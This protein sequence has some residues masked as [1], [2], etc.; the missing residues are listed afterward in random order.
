[1]KPRLDDKNVELAKILDELLAADVKIT[2]REVSRRHSSLRNASDFSRNGER[3]TLIE[4]AK[5]RQSQLRTT[6]NPHAERATS[7][8]NKLEQ[9]S[10]QVV[11]LEAQV[12]ALVASHAGCIQAVLHAGGMSAVERFWKDYSAVGDTLREVSAFPGAAEVVQ[13]RDQKLQE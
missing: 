10:Q 13:L 11:Q 9:R 3:M 12:R 1:V 8:A 6:L 7:L 5:S 4:H 2:V